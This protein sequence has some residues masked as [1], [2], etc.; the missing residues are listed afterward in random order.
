MKEYSKDKK[1]FYVPSNTHKPIWLEKFFLMDNENLIQANSKVVLIDKVIID[2]KEIKFAVVFGQ[3]KALF[4]DDV[5]E[6]QFGLKIVLNLA[7]QNPIRKISKLSIGGNQKQSQEQMPKTTSINDFGFEVDRDLIK[8]VT[9]KCNDEIFGKG[10]ITGGDILSIQANTDINNIDKFLEQCYKKYKEDNY[11]TNFDWVDNIK[12]IK[13]KEIK[14]RLNDILIEYIKNKK[15][16]NVWMIVPEIIQWE[17]INGFRYGNNEEIFDDIEIENVIKDKDINSINDLKKNKICVIDEDGNE[18]NKWNAF[19]C[20]TAE[21]EYG[22]NQYCLNNERWYKIDKNYANRIK[23]EYNKIKI[24]NINFIDYDDT[25]KKEDDYNEK[26]SNSL[27]GSYLMHK[28]G[29]IP[30]GEGT[31]NKI[32]LCDIMTN[33]NE[34]IHIKKNGGSAYLSHLFNQAT[35]SAE[36]L[37]DD[38]FRKKSNNKIAKVGFDFRFPNDF[39]ASDYTIIIAIITKNHDRIPKIPF[40][41]QV[42]IRYAERMLRNLGYNVEMKNIVNIKK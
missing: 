14:E 41:S 40:F 19:K 33:K 23:N 7:E 20:I 11:K 31:G 27:D 9:I 35:V 5:F 4:A 3:A 15:W 32:E 1:A 42:S 36:L 22:E 12:Y 38:E 13:S 18:I 39:K 10:N 2:G 21:I 30:F 25:M 37:L 24:S 8:F 17:K 34:L 28:V 29:E 6:E 26:L 16:E